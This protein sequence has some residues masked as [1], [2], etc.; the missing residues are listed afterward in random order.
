MRFKKVAYLFIAFIAAAAAAGGIYIYLLE[1]QEEHRLATEYIPV[2]VATQNI[3]PNETV[4][5]EMF[6]LKEVPRGYAHPDAMQEFDSLTGGISKGDIFE[7]EQVLEGKIVKAGETGDEFVYTIRP[8]KR[9]V[10]I[11]L[12]EVVGVGGLIFPGDYVDIVATLDSRDEDTYFDY[13]KIIIENIR[14]L[15]VGKRYDPLKFRE[16][17]EQAGTITLE[18]LPEE[19]PPLV[20]ASEKGSIR[21]LLRSPGDDGVPETPTWKMNDYLR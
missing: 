4:G 18:V 20:L 16:V 8:G 14:V 12:N 10:A 17:T 3:A 21:L 19:A 1:L 9:A 13:S 2:V 5:H 7:G 15:A 11:P 6:A